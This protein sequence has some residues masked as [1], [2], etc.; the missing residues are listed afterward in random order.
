MTD[1]KCQRRT[2]QTKDPADRVARLP[3]GYQRSDDAKGADEEHQDGNDEEG[4]VG[5]GRG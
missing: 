3:R 1:R 2:T 5:L 4:L